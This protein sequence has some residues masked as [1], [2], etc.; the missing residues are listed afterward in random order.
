MNDQR[1][2]S[3]QLGRLQ[4]NCL[5]SAV[6]FF[7]SPRI[8]AVPDLCCI[9]TQRLV[10]LFGGVFDYMVSSAIAVLEHSVYCRCQQPV[11]T[12]H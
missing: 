3:L 12:P 5:H 7:L 10:E 1:T 11:H 4:L 6:L 9:V 2:R 8:Y